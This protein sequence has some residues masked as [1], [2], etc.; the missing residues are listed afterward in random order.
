MNDQPSDKMRL[1]VGLG[2]PGRRYERTRHNVGF[3]VADRLAQLWLID[4][5]KAM[6]GGQFAEATVNRGDEVRRVKLL[7]PENF[8][9]ASGQPARQAADYYRVS[10]EDV[11]VVLDDI[12]LPLGRLRVRQ[13]GSAG[14]HNGL[15]DVIRAFGTD[16]V[17]RLRVGVGQPPKFMA[18]EDYVLAAFGE[19]EQDTIASAIRLAAKAADDWLFEGLTSVMDRYNRPAESDEK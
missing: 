6:F 13:G 9:N 12:A 10:S 5:G 16:K 2:N 15:A 11:L 8:M 17:A 14:G 4:S 1:V 19:D 7:K 18:S 3:R